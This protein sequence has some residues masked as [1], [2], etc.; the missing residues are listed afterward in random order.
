MIMRMKNIFHFIVMLIV[1]SSCCREGN[2]GDATV[3]VQLERNGNFIINH[4]GYPDTVYIKYNSKDLPGTHIEDFDT[5][6]VGETGEDHIHCTT[7]KCGDYFFYT[8][9]FDS[10]INSRVTGGLHVK[11]KHKERKNELT[12]NVQVGF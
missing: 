3:L 4:V 6:F 1:V 2:N 7:L 11:I 12:V 8:A 10:T 5:Y 9:G